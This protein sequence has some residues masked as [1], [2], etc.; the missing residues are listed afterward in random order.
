MAAHLF[1]EETM[2]MITKTETDWLEYIW[3][4]KF[5]IFVWDPCG[6]IPH[7]CYRVCNLVANVQPYRPL[8]EA[9]CLRTKFYEAVRLR[10]K[11]NPSKSGLA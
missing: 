1:P 10:T 6:C 4:P 7:L 5:S 9:V 3:P 11:F 2:T 8:P